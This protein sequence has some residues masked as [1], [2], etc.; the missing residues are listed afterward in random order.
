M[1]ADVITTFNRS[2]LPVAGHIRSCVSGLPGM[3]FHGIEVTS[4]SSLLAR[5]LRETPGV[6]Y[7][8]IML[9]SSGFSLSDLL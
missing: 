5:R 6:I 1:A 3:E 4:S 7:K 8:A 2:R 9:I